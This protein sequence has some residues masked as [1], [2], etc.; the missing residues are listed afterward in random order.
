MECCGFLRLGNSALKI[1]DRKVERMEVKGV[2]HTFGYGEGRS[3]GE[4]L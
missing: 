3:G 2:D 1:N 4:L